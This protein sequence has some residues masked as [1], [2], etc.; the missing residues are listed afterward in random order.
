MNPC[1]Y[2]YMY[3][4]VY[5][6]IH[7]SVYTPSFDYRAHMNISRCVM[8]TIVISPHSAGIDSGGK[9][10]ELKNVENWLMVWNIFYFSIYWECHHPNWLS[11]YSEGWLNH[12]GENTWTLDLEFGGRYDDY[13]IFWFSVYFRIIYEI[14]QHNIMYHNEI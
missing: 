11:Y 9:I 8:V 10:Q 3:V 5:V 13:D 14:P 12:Q 7:I 4:Y 6:Y 1:I 2:I